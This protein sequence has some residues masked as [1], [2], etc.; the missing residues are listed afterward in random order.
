MRGGAP[1][2]NDENVARLPVERAVADAAPAASFR[3]AAHSGVSRSVAGA[4]ESGRQQL[5][6]R[7][8][9]RHGITARH[10]IHILHLDAMMRMHRPTA[11]HLM[12][13]F[14]APGIWVM[15]YRRG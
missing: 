11:V 8:D 9:G 6:K 14:A 12:Q 13:R 5:K 2:W 10:R 1:G 3:D 7:A 15:E 4:V